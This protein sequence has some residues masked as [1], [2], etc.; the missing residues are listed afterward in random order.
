MFNLEYQIPLV[1]DEKVLASIK[2]VKQKLMNIIINS[3]DNYKGPALIF[4]EG[5]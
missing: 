3:F 4:F 5:C 2:S 1:G